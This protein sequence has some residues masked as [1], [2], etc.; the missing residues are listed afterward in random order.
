VNEAI[1]EKAKVRAIAAELS[2]SASTISREIHGNRTV[3]PNGQSHY[4]AM[5]RPAPC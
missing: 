2:R 3:L 1:R 5:R 4:P